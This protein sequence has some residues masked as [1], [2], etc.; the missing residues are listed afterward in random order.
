MEDWKMAEYEVWHL[1]NNPQ[2]T[3]SQQQVSSEV[4]LY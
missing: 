2:G 4:G 1:S 3:E